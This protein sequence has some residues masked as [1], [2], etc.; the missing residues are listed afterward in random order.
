M[1]ALSSG[2]HWGWITNI[3][4]ILNTNGFDIWLR[5]EPGCVVDLNL[6]NSSIEALYAIN[7]INGIFRV[8]DVV[9]T[10]KN[11]AVV[12]AAAVFNLGGALHAIFDRVQLYGVRTD[13]PI[14]GAIASNNGDFRNCNF[15]GCG[16][17]GPSNGGVCYLEGGVF[18]FS[19]CNWNDF[20]QFG[21]TAY[22]AIQ[23]PN[24]SWVQATTFQNIVIDNCEFD[25]DQHAAV[26][27]HQSSAGTA[28]NGSAVYIRATNFNAANPV[29]GPGQAS[30][31][32]DGVGVNSVVVD[33]C[34]FGSPAN[35]IC[36]DLTSV[37]SMRMSR[38]IGTYFDGANFDALAINVISRSGNGHWIFENNISQV[39]L[40]TSAGAP[41]SVLITSKGTTAPH[42]TSIAGCRLFLLP[43]VGVTFGA[44]ATTT[45]SGATYAA[46]TAGHHLDVRVDGITFIFTFAGTEASQAAFHAVINTTSPSV[47][48]AANAAGQTQLVTNAGFAQGFNGINSGEILTSSSADVLTSLGLASGQFASAATVTALL[49]Q[50]GLVDATHNV[51]SGAGG[52]PTMI[53]VSAAFGGQPTLLFSGTQSLISSVWSSSLPQGFTVLIVGRQV[54]A[55]TVYAFDG[56]AGNQAAIFSKTSDN[57]VHLDAGLD[58]AFLSGAAVNVTSAGAFFGDFEHQLSVPAG[59]VTVLAGA[60][61]SSESHDPGGGA[62]TGVTVGNKG[63]GSS[64]AG[65]EIGA[66]AVYD[67][68]LADSEIGALSTWARQRFGFKAF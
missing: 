15:L 34:T 10:G 58:A 4:N 35:R 17:L 57:T 64:S 44:S 26:W 56:L 59:F 25:E 28:L 21:G 55:G 38:C 45:G 32:V 9:F 66:V 5:G 65:W 47:I 51:S 54:T 19:H 20:G 60:K 62:L 7:N 48:S 11:G 33:S 42:P 24:G 31:L 18:T 29:L 13:A 46:V 6:A 39:R 3:N 68:G 53:G 61:R 8:S 14:S 36:A 2:Q 50:S 23:G 16:F 52:A 22:G 37:S 43:D 67:H 49:D 27:C 12:D 63:D 41:E 1:P 30:I 40:D